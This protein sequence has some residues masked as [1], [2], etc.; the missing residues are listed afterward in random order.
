MSH[1]SITVTI[2]EQNITFETGKIARQANGAVIVRCGETLIFST[3][4]AT[5]KP[6]E[7]TD[8]L[9]LKVDYQEPLSASGKTNSGFVNV[10]VDLPKEKF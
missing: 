6:G 1:E 5:T 3:A 4:C 10:K 8:F 9:P 7:E 2:G